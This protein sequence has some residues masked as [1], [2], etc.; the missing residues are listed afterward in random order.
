MNLD[1]EYCELTVPVSQS[2]SLSVLPKV[3]SKV[4]VFGF[5][6]SSSSLRASLSEFETSAHLL[7]LPIFGSVFICSSNSLVLDFDSV[8]LCKNTS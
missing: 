3:S 6:F 1:F 7:L 8:N 5:G 4:M 2:V